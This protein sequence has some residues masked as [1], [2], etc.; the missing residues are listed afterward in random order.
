MATAM[1]RRS[2]IREEIRKRQTALETMNPELLKEFHKLEEFV[3]NGLRDMVMFYHAVGVTANR[4]REDE[5]TYGDHAVDK[6]AD[7]LNRDRT[8]I[9]RAAAMASWLTEK[10]LK[11]FLDQEG[12][13]GNPLSWSHLGLLVSVVDVKKREELIQDVIDQGMSA[14][15]LK[16]EIERRERTSQPSGSN[17]DFSPKTYLGGISQLSNM[18]ARM[19]SKLEDADRTIF[20]KGL[21]SSIN[22]TPKVIEET[23]KARDALK[24]MAEEALKKAEAL[25]DMEGQLMTRAAEEE[26]T[27]KE[28]A[29]KEKADKEKADKEKAQANGKAGGG[30]GG[31]K[32]GKK[33]QRR[34]VTA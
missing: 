10:Q 5:Q 22:I 34:P 19:Y 17:R 15:S 32:K 21:V 14:R 16:T 33:R 13:Y 18:S 9:F 23:G 26:K 11:E 30:A 31:K 28:A 12:P 27:A 8:N 25:D 29:A 20:R 24:A 3:S 2:P 1:A 6:L 7:A 4:I